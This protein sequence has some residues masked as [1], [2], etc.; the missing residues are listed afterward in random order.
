MNYLINTITN[1]IVQNSLG[2]NEESLFAINGFEDIAIYGKLCE[3]ITSE[4]DHT[5][6]SVSIKLA[7]KKWEGFQKRYSGSPYLIS[8][9]QNG[10]TSEGKSATYFRNLHATDVLI[11]MGTEEEDDAVGSLK[12]ITTIT[13]SNLIDLVPKKNKNVRYDTIFPFAENFTVDQQNAI[14][15]LYKDLF[16]F[17]SPDLIRLSN[18]AD[19]WNDQVTTFQDFESLF[20]ET[21]PEWGLPKRTD[22]FPTT[23]QLK[24][25]KNLLR[26]EFQFITGALFTP[27]SAAKYRSYKAKI[28][29]YETEQ[30]TYS[31]TWSGWPDQE[32]KNYPDFSNALL[33]YISG[34][35]T[36]KLQQSF[37][38]TNF[39]I[40]EDVLGIKLEPNS[41]EA[42]MKINGEPLKAFTGAILDI[43]SDVKEKEKNGIPF[44][45]IVFKFSEATIVVNDDDPNS[46]VNQWRNICIHTNGVFEYIDKKLMLSVN[47]EDV[48][49]A[50]D[51]ADFFGITK[52]EKPYVNK[53]SSNKSVN[54]IGFKIQYLDEND[55]KVAESPRKECEWLFKYNESWLN[56][57]TDLCQ[58][59][60]V[61][62]QNNELIPLATNNKLRS[63][64]LSKSQD[65]F[66]AILTEESN[67]E[68][69]CDL[70]DQNVYPN[71]FKNH[72]LYPSFYA[73]GLAFS[74]F[75]NELASLG[76]YHVLADTSGKNSINKLINEY[77]KLG[78]KIVK[79]KINENERYILNYFVHA[80]N[81]EESAASVVSEKEI[82][83]CIV[84]PWHPASLEK[85]KHMC[86]FF[87]DGCH[88]Y[89]K[90][91]E[92]K[93]KFNSKSNNTEKI[94][95]LS[96][97]SLFQNSVDLF[98]STN[99]AFF[100]ATK[101]YGLY[102]V[103]SDKSVK[104]ESSF[105]DLIDKDAVFDDDFK[106]GSYSKMNDD[107][108]MIFNVLENYIKAFP[109]SKDNLTLVFVDPVELQPVIAAL[110]K[111]IEEYHAKYGSES[112]IS[113]VLKIL[114]KPENLGGK[115]YL[116][117]WMNETFDLDSYVKVKTY[118]SVWNNQEELNSY[119]DTNN[120]IVFVMDLLKINEYSFISKLDSYKPAHDECYFPIVFRPGLISVTHSKR[121]VI[122]LTQPQF[123]A[124]TI[125]TQVVY[126]RSHMEKLPESDYYA[127][128]TVIID[129]DGEKIVKD[130]HQKAYWVVC[131]DNGMDGALLRDQ[132]Q[133]QQDYS[134]IGFSTGKGR[135]GQYNMTITARNSIVQSIQKRFA[136]RLF[137]MFHWEYSQIEQASR[138]CMQE[139]S[140]LDGISVLRA[141]NRNDYNINEFMAYV[142]TSLREKE[143]TCNTP[144]KTIVHL[145]SYKHWFSGKWNTKTI[146][147]SEFSQ[148]RP[149]FLVL[150][151]DSNYS[152]K[153]KIHA[154][155]IECK[156]AGFENREEHLTKAIK[157]VQHGHEVLSE[158]FNPDSK[159]LKRRYW[160]AQLYRA[161]AFAQVTFASS[162]D[163]YKVVSDKLREILNG[164]FE[165]EWNG[166]I[167]GY[168]V[169][170][171]G[172]KETED[173]VEDVTIVNVPQTKIQK[174]LLQNETIPV[175]YQSDVDTSLFK[176][177]QTENLEIKKR[178]GELDEELEEKRRNVKVKT[179]PIREPFG[180][181]DSVIL[182]DAYVNMIENGD[183]IKQTAEH[184]S[185]VLKEWAGR[186]GH[187]VNNSY[188]TIEGLQGRIKAMQ[189]AFDNQHERVPEVFE[190]VVKMYREDRERFDSILKKELN[191]QK[192]ETEDR[193]KII[194][195][196]EPSIKI[197]VSNEKNTESIIDK[198]NRFQE[199]P[200]KV[201]LEPKTDADDI[202]VK[203]GKSKFNEDV[204]WEFG[205]K[206]LA[207][208]HLLITGTSGQGKTYCI[209]TMLYE[210]SKS[211]I[212]S[213]IFDYTE[214][215]TP[216]QLEP[217]FTEL[218]GDRIHQE[219]VIGTGV[220]INPFKRQE[221]EIVGMKMPEKIENVASRIA[222]IFTHVY[223]FGEQQYSAIFNAARN[224]MRKYG[225]QMNMDYFRDELEKLKPSNPAAKTVI[226]KMEPFLYSIEFTGDSSFDWGN[227]LY[228]KDALVTIF[229]LTHIDRDMQVI[230]TELLLWDAWYYTQ[231]VGSKDAPF[232]VVLDEAQNLSH[233]DSSPSAK[234]L[235]EGRK[236]GWSA[237][238]AT[239]SLKVLTDD[240]VVRL[241]QSAFKLYFKPTEDEITKISKQIDP[242]EGNAWVP[243]IKGLS[244]GRCIVAG[245]RLRR[246]GSFGSVKPTVVSVDSF[247]S[248]D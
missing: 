111:Y 182:L 114:V 79:S 168:W 121:R 229:Q 110:N 156:I 245:D 193:D 50:C 12:E 189:R 100:G 132:N 95:E 205:H 84:P 233:K 171:N 126:Y 51:P 213:V 66:N 28:E 96:E 31:S 206:Q 163:E 15:K 123:E 136:D 73:L 14:N 152:E 129:D 72:I 147:D 99:S 115:N 56:S 104:S 81:I 119:L 33:E 112:V 83:Y 65:D 198:D 134:V 106:A 160:F 194:D 146:F 80:F 204:Y 13:P 26:P 78:D 39:S 57:Y 176:D 42:G 135:F 219:V 10:W 64:V 191:L 19:K 140:Y 211:N 169:N 88:E 125:H 46:L 225:D 54:K 174:L 105:K 90:T 141:S 161:L 97:L 244:K 128:K 55:K 91:V 85:F 180:V 154:K 190:K 148:S 124:A 196:P 216:D 230:I 68:F 153:V 3:A 71:D 228:S 227:I 58:Q 43:V 6:K 188:R 138:I 76:I 155:I 133:H 207:N 223:G 92:E 149:D 186:N 137:K 53:A 49:I 109:N 60:F 52:M 18:H 98:P 144:L 35:R 7:T 77:T 170:L 240:E 122:E 130:L 239:Q 179:V 32:I 69:S 48:S 164:D 177:E 113:I 102:T 150:E 162:S 5:D 178:E 87:I 221:I 45:K 214:G 218:M 62:V 4:L 120:D 75:A 36:R 116:T 143:K 25:R 86:L 24:G 47:G 172:D 231:K 108:L 241:M 232:V 157:Q 11:L 145:D 184:L 217:K 242:T 208:R 127:V 248:R 151:V 117:Y 101:T 139:A 203:I 246:D 89:L 192:S 70:L 8:M 63:L 243:A 30:K 103:Y 16:E 209:Q 158:I 59:D 247:E 226:S 131:I 234:I 185:E 1:Y 27:I 187:S 23:S 202:R 118:L 159:S 175:K 165:I 82:E 238:Y 236:F 93:N 22:R 200:E 235:T 224:G 9:K 21:L 94:N 237:W 17:Y 197:T 210:L 67:T 195:K 220:P 142:L 20:Y 212:S 167:L 38:N 2:S 201:E 61:N 181:E 74:L 44:S 107:A 166:E 41:K 222:S 183:T 215:F 37:L 34:E 40:V 173:I 29:K 199:K